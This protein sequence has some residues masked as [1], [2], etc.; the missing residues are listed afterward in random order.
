M[1][2]IAVFESLFLICDFANAA[3]RATSRSV[4]TTRKNV[5]T[6]AT[7][8]SQLTAEQETTTTEPVVEQIASESAE[9]VETPLILQNKSN[10]FA[11]IVSE[12]MENAGPDN[13]FAE[14]IRQQ[15]EA[16]AASEASYLTTSSQNKALSSNSHSCDVELRKCMSSVCGN[17]FTKCATDGDTI[18]GDK[19]NKCKRDTKCSA[20]EFSQFAKEIKADRDTNV[21]LAGYNAVLDCGNNYNACIMNE[22]GTTYNKCLGKSGENS[23]IQKCAT[24]ARECAESDSGLSARFG[25]AIGKLRENAESDIKKDESRLYAL[26]DSMEKQCKSLG[27]TFDS[28]TFD[29]V[30]TV[31]FFAGENQSVPLASRKAYAGDSF[32]C[33]Q[34]WF[35]INTTTAR[36]NAYR[37]TASQTA[38][39]SAMLGSGVGM[40][41]GTLSSGAVNRA[42]ETTKAKNELNK[43]EKEL[44]NAEKEQQKN[45]QEIKN[46]DD[47]GGS[48][49][50]LGA[51]I[52]DKITGVIGNAKKKSK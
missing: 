35:G 11:A 21:Q 1:T 46:E 52:K 3:T 33:N 39:S 45:E 15:R 40:V 19:L 10:Q 34:E 23:A 30:Y 42:I 17:D 6:V 29:C 28:R 2:A 48:G 9:V 25:T 22:C 27:A 4:P 18:F 8:T 26:R 7:T 36:E 12:V 50:G 5:S 20:Q 24:I 49:S 37:E 51:I 13:S 47:Q 41:A 44:K 14:L 31:E 43:A 38:A 32:V 16:L